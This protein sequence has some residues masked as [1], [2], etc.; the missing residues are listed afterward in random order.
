[1]NYA[2][3][4]KQIRRTVL[5]MVY[6]AQSSHIGSCF[7]AVEIL[8]AIYDKADFAKDELVV[9]K[10]WCAA[11]VY[12]LN[13]YHG[14]IPQ[15]DL[16][17]FNQEGSKYIGL[18]EPIGGF[19]CNVGTGSMGN[20]LPMALGFAMADRTKK[21]SVLMSDGEMNS[22]TTWES[23]F[24]AKHHML[25]NLIVF[26][27]CNKWQ[28]MGRTDDVLKI[29]LPAMWKACGWNVFEIDGHDFAALEHVIDTGPLASPTVV[30]CN[31]IKGKGVSFM[32]DQ[33]KYHYKN[34]SKEEYDIACAELS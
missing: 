32:E 28:A 7:S 27:D 25:K 14:L 31:T 5:N 33:L 12:A 22:G 29:D 11:L 6:A 17:T 4:A 15:K 16:L 30:L 19:G 26:V 21:V 24:I 2:E 8:C 13:A 10:G 34:L 23:A 20:G 9:S 1:M 18:I 3:K